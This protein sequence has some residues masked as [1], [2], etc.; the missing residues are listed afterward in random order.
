MRWLALALPF[1]GVNVL[2]LTFAR[3][4]RRVRRI[5]ALQVGLSLTILSLT[6]ILIGSLGITGAGIAFFAGQSLM[7]VL[8]SRR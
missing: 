7:A 3:M 5:V 1:M 4:G 8:S 6:E 2:Y